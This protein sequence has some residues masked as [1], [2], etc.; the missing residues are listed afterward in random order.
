ME[1]GLLINYDFCTG[2]HSCE[3]ACKKEH[4]LDL[5]QFGIKLTQYGP[6]EYAPEK[7]DYIFIP[8]PTSLCD[9]CADRVDAG[10]KPTCVKHCSAQVMTYGPVEELAKQIGG[11]HK[12]VIF[13]P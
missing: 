5:D 6:V 13:V 12:C 11:R 3:V 7:W 4:G 8:A 1:N 9:L 2:C 10:K